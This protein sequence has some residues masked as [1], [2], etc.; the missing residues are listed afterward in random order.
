M[1]QFDSTDLQNASY[2]PRNF[3]HESM[4][5]RD[6][7][8][9]QLARDDGGVL[10][11]ERFASKII[12]IQGTLKASTQA[13][14]E[15][16][17]D[18]YKELLSRKDKN[19]DI[20]FAGGTRRYVAYA[21]A[22]TIDRD[23]F[24]LLFVPYQIEFVVPGGMGVD[25][26]ETAAVNAVD[27]DPTYTGAM[28]L[29]GSA[30]PKPKITLTIGT[31]WTNALGIRFL[32][33]DNN[34]ECI[35]T[36]SAVFSNADVLIIDCDLKKVTL[37]AVEIP[38]YRVIP[39]FKI[40][41]NN[42]SIA[43]GDI[44]DQKFE[45]PASYTT[46]NGT[47]NSGSAIVGQSFMVSHSDTTYQGIW[48]RV[49][50]PDAPDYDLAIEI[51]TDNN[52]EPSGTAV[53][54]ATFTIAAADVGASYAWL[55]ANSASKF[56]LSANT[57]YWI[58]CKKGAG[59]SSGTYWI[60]SCYGSEANYG[61]GNMA[62]NSGAWQQLLN[63]YLFFRLCFGGKADSSAPNLTLDVDYTKRYL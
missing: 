7:E 42:F 37:N 52:G 31:G 59:A 17:I 8:I 30:L 13:A 48:L 21:R 38:F 36:R 28:T 12:T 26:S 25:T 27:A 16:L 4:P 1:I 32:N 55:I 51:Q 29:A 49:L 56:S 40:G 60:E 6:L 35:I 47:V 22:F 61:K 18:T 24:H 46:F 33:I 14:L 63:Y 9:L 5:D 54:N 11:S 15:A 3:K 50:K 62:I 43:A 57:R 45:P 34:E 44:I 53:T 10:V 20:S 23:H 2:V 39:K 58:V 41:T 19:L